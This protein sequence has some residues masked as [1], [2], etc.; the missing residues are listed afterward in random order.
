M[1]PETIFESGEIQLATGENLIP[2]GRIPARRM[3]ERH[4]HSAV[5]IG[6]RGTFCARPMLFYTWF[7]SFKKLF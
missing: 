4:P 2:V 1:E 7:F 6:V 5:I 3:K